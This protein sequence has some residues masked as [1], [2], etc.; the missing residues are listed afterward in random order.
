MLEVDPL[1]PAHIYSQ[2]L[3]GSFLS[4][5]QGFS[6]SR[7]KQPPILK[8]ASVPHPPYNTSVVADKVAKYHFHNIAR[9]SSGWMEW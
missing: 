5:T 4:W 6:F 3:S 2:R 9:Q 1:T 8:E 7:A